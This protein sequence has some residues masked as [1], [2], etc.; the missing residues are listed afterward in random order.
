MFGR[1]LLP[2]GLWCQQLKLY[3][4]VR[5]VARLGNRCRRSHFAQLSEITVTIMLRRLAKSDVLSNFSKGGYRE[6]SLGRLKV[7]AKPPPV[8]PP[9]VRRTCSVL[10]KKYSTGAAADLSMVARVL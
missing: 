1:N 7:F 4:V 5:L 9:V 2:S 3:G 6:S 10:E 8:K